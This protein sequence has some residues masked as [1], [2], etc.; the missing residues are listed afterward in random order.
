MSEKRRRVP[1]SLYG[2][3]DGAFE[4]FPGASP[5]GK[6]RGRK[7]NDGKRREAKATSMWFAYE[8][9]VDAQLAKAQAA[10]FYVETYAR[11]YDESHGHRGMKIRPE[12]EIAAATARL[13]A[14]KAEIRR[15]LVEMDSLYREVTCDDDDGSVDVETVGCSKCRK[16]ESSDDDDILLCDR[17]GCFRAWH[18]SCAEVQNDELN[19]DPE[20]DWFC[21]IC[22][23]IQRCIDKINE[24]FEKDYETDRW[25][26]VFASDDESEEADENKTDTILDDAIRRDDSDESD[27]SDFRS[28]AKSDDD[29]T[30][31]SSDCSGDDPVALERD[32]R[33]EKAVVVE[34]VDER[35]ILDTKRRRTAVDYVALD[36]AL[37]ALEGTYDSDDDDW[38]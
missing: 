16:F 20:D 19:D 10:R 7:K 36:T 27:D 21:P 4:G 33:P 28:E 15:I 12:R 22:C 26:S 2:T 23:C 13:A 31:L 34:D 8:R 35:N 11:D 24:A 1:V 25:H 30:D 37:S 38:S 5:P 18:V 29:G 9:K 17:A 6:R 32:A 3:E 14:A